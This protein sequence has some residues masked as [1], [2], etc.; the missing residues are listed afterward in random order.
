METMSIM[1]NNM[2]DLVLTHRPITHKGLHCPAKKKIYCVETHTIF[3][4]I[5]EAANSMK[6]IRQAIS[7]CINHHRHTTGGFH[8]IEVII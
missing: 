7:Y 5:T 3:N 4:S 2:N 8:F 6:L 1:V